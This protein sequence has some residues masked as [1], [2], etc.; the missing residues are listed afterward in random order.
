MRPDLAEDFSEWLVTRGAILLP[1]TNE[2][3]VLRFRLDNSVGV[4]YRNKHGR[5]SFNSQWTRDL[6]QQWSK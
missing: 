3:E 1:A 2:W 5:T 4:V 6:H